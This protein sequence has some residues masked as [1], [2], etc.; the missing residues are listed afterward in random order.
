M[1]TSNALLQIGA[2]FEISACPYEVS[3]V[4]DDGIRISPKQG[5]SQR[6]LTFEAINELI[7]DDAIEMSYTP[8][9]NEKQMLS[10]LTDQQANYLRRKYS[11]VKGVYDQHSNPCSQKAIAPTVFKIAKEIK[12]PKPPSTS[13]VAS[14]IKKWVES[15][16][17]MIVLAPKGKPSRSSLLDLIPE[18]AR[19]VTKAVKEV[20]L[21]RQKNPVSAVMA[22]IRI[23]LAEYNAA[24]EE[25]LPL[26]SQSTIQRF[27]HSLDSYQ[28]ARKRF[29]KPYADRKFRAAG[30][31][32][33][34]TEPLE[35]VMAD[36]QIMDIIIVRELEDGSYE[37][38]GRP[39]L[40]LIIDVR[41]RTVL[42][43]HISLAPFCGATLLNA[44]ADA[45]VTDGAKPKGIPGKLI[46]DNGSDYLS[47]GFLKACNRMSIA[48]E[49]CK[50]RDPNA[51]AIVERFFRTM[52]TDLIHKFPGTTFSNPEDRGDYNS[53]EMAR[54]KL[55]DLRNFVATWIEHT[56]HV[57][58]HRTLQ[59]APIDI[60]NEEA[61]E[62]F[63]NTL[64]REDATILLRDTR[65]CTLSQGCVEA[66]GLKWSCHSLM[67]WEND[68]RRQ[69]RDRKVIIQIDELD[70]SEVYIAT[71]DTPGHYHKALSRR[72]QYTTG[73]SLYEHNQ[74]K[75]ELKKKRTNARMIRMQDAELYKLRLEFY[76]ALGH[77][78]D[79]IAKRKLE[80]LMD[81]EAA[82]RLAQES[83]SDPDSSDTSSDPDTQSTDES[84]EDHAEISSEANEDSPSNSNTQRKPHYPSTNVN[85]R[86]PL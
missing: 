74:L 16:Y 81:H 6:F 13:S 67:G 50:P 56:Y 71:K 32:F 28:V 42:G 63:P 41:T 9:P 61:Q 70:L 45:V 8:N 43:F 5:G 18:L 27:I 60:W 29:G 33:F 73:L 52:N 47:S 83:T 11:Y 46:I 48:I 10:A 80:R 49:A 53:Q 17:Q 64:T 69:G 66:H 54:L 51:K 65:E 7:E 55:E 35:M 39:F 58:D 23:E 20:Y 19:I 38:I 12:D 59:R 72:P 14:W 34:A 37:E 82:K 77:G 22:T 36:G 1:N 84:S 75:A 21:N 40:T 57:R 4:G 62:I 68:Q 24:H 25:A 3:F 31:G 30:I 78:D 2:Q 15:G 26:P 44:L 76:A 79:K 86:A 85:K